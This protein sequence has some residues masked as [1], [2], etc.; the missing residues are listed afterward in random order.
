MNSNYI[1]CFL[2]CSSTSWLA[3][4]GSTRTLE[5]ANWYTEDTIVYCRLQRPYKFVLLCRFLLAVVRSTGQVTRV[6]PRAATF[7][8][9]C[10]V[11]YINNV[12]VID[13][14]RTLQQPT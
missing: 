10:T 3:I 14:L 4:A 5:S 1:L 7:Y 12:L 13:G 6:A 2:T 9:Y 8:D 11:G